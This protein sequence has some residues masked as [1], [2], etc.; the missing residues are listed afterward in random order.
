MNVSGTDT[1]AFYYETF[2]APRDWLGEEDV[3]HHSLYGTVKDLLC[4]RDQTWSFT[5]QEVLGIPHTFSHGFAKDGAPDAFEAPTNRSHLTFDVIEPKLAVRRHWRIPTIVLTNGVPM[6]RREWYQ[7]GRILGKFMRVVMVDLF[8][9]GDSGMPIDFYDP[10]DADRPFAERR[11]YWRWETHARILAAFIRDIDADWKIE[12]RVFLGANDWGAGAV[13]KTS[14][15]FGEQLLLG[16]GVFS[17]VMLDGYWVWQIGALDGFN[18]IPFPSPQFAAATRQFL[19][20]VTGL[21]ETMYN[22]PERHTNQYTMALNQWPFVD[23]DYSNPERNPSN[24]VF[25]PWA[26]RVLA[27]QGATILGNG[28]LLPFHP[29]HNPNGMRFSAWQGPWMFMHGDGDK[30]MPLVQIFK[31]KAIA[32]DLQQMRFS[33]DRDDTLE[34]RIHAV[35]DAGHFAIRDQ[36]IKAAH[37]IID[38]VRDIVG[39]VLLANPYLGLEGLAR[40]SERYELKQLRIRYTLDRIRYGSGYF[41]SDYARALVSSQDLKSDAIILS[42]SAKV[43]GAYTLSQVARGNLTTDTPL[44]HMS[45]VNR[46]V[47][48]D[49]LQND[50][51]VSY[52]AFKDNL[53]SS[54][55]YA[56]GITLEFEF[57]RTG[58]LRTRK[59]R[60]KVSGVITQPLDMAEWA[61]LP[62]QGST[63]DPDR[64]WM[65]GSKNLRRI[66]VLDRATSGIKHVLL[67]DFFEKD[68]VAAP[69]LIATLRVGFL[70]NGAIAEARFLVRP[71]LKDAL[72]TAN[73]GV[74]LV[75]TAKVRG[76]PR[77]GIT[78]STHLHVLALEFQPVLFGTLKRMQLVRIFSYVIPRI[79][80]VRSRPS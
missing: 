37:F 7:V 39:P 77:A 76:D 53:G 78:K 29:T 75:T 2:N 12:G 52:D 15:M 20:T 23:I 38:W 74:V 60:R 69:S 13:Q 43:A 50:V 27:E 14:E 54:T 8:G 80:R 36:P 67:S 25:H 66:V 24:S 35:V 73:G 61:I 58:A 34:M 11:W 45:A 46:N 65:L 79:F 72:R 5:Y 42:P 9:M 10:A 57:F 19:G 70:A 30:M 31:M 32:M 44:R 16:T 22:H 56:R 40:Q 6:N 68:T 26:V 33:G 48:V 28:E 21:I 59:R 17:A 64:D 62:S 55:R 47:L 3:L 51:D 18:H 71:T 1:D 63:T 49:L 41:T 4:T